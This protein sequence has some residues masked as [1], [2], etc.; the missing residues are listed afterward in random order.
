VTTWKDVP[1]PRDDTCPCVG[2]CEITVEERTWRHIAERHVMSGVEPWDE[3]LSSPVAGRFRKSW[4]VGFSDQERQNTLVAVAAAVE[5]DVKQCLNVPLGLLYDDYQPPAPSRPS[6]AQ[7]TWGLVLPC[8]AYLVVRSRP[9]GGEVRTCYFK[10]VVCREAD[11]TQ[12]WRR[13]TQNV[14]LTYARVNPDGTFC[15]PDRLDTVVP[16]GG[17]RARIRFRTEATWRLDCKSRKPWESMTDP[18]RPPP[19]PGP[20]A[21]ALRPR[22]TY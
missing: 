22:R 19:P 8:G 9:A 20:P 15:S 6:K 14:L 11:P 21:T 17:L 4:S 5:T 10:G 3:W 18:W 2:R 13:L 1:D 16:D 12:R 7:E